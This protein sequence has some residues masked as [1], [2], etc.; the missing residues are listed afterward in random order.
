MV[1]L[2]GFIGFTLEHKTLALILSLKEAV[3]SLPSTQWEALLEVKAQAWHR[4]RLQHLP[5]EG[6]TPPG[7][8]Y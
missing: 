8:L 5:E 7:S 4:C 2:N 1:S 6:E 3:R